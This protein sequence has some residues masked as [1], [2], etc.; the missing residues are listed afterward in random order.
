M[1]KA[2]RAVGVVGLGAMGEPIARHLALA[3]HPLLVVDPERTA[4]AQAADIPGV[5]VARTP[6]E[7]AETSALVLI[8]VGNDEQVR[9]V[10][11]GPTGV[12][13]AHAA[14][15]VLVC[16]TVQ[17]ATVQELAARAADLGV[18]LLD[19]ALVGGLRAAHAGGLT[20]LV[21]GDVEALDG[22]RPELAAWTQSVHHLG[23]LGAGQ[24]A[25]SANNLIHWA[26]VCAI[27]EAF[28]IVERAGL[29]VPAVR[30]ALQDGPAD[31]RALH[32]LELMKFTWWRKDLIGYTALAEELGADHSVGD[33]CANL[34]PAISVEEIA[35]LFGPK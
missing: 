30:R 20:L 14:T 16:S 11:T 1:T 26:Q 35:T 24:I 28:R 17:P 27:H 3:G 5:Q 9:E 29:S 8:V 31:S 2:R 23:P 13:A 25:K 18:A 10:V 19:A 15:T 12:L 6:A 7:L 33:L 34:M 22:V 32:E 4:T 21:G